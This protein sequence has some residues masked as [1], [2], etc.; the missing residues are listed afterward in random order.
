MTTRLKRQNILGADISHLS[1]STVDGIVAEV[2]NLR[3]I[4]RAV[5]EDEKFTTICTRRD[6]RTLLK[7]VKDIFR[8]LGALRTTLNDIVL[9]PSIAPRVREM[10]LNPKD[11]SV[12]G[13]S[14]T[15]SLGGGWM[16]PLTKLFTATTFGESKRPLS[17]LGMSRGRGPVR[18]SSRP[19]PKLGPATA[20]STTTVNVEFTGTGAGRAI[21]CASSQETRNDAIATPTPARGTYNLKGI[22]A[23]ATRIDPWIVLP[24]SPPKQPGLEADQLRRATLGRAAGRATDNPDNPL[25]RNVD[26]VIDPH[27][28]PEDRRGFDP[29][30][31]LRTRGLS[32]SSIR[33]TFLHHGEAAMAAGLFPA[34]RFH[35][36]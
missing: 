14:S 6:L 2:A 34:H 31:T 25:S 30:R 12:N 10:T 15:S 11:E 20:A 28:S 21:T 4:F 35:R 8:E 1:R 33:S 32:D 13:K 7:L 5:L 16:A 17:P 23:G 36:A 3:V 27:G 29:N 19:I 26:A 22:F 24:T 9:D 18:S